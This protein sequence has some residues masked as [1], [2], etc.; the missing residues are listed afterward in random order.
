MPAVHRNGGSRYAARP[1]R[2]GGGDDDDEEKDDGV[3]AAASSLDKGKPRSDSSV[4]PRLNHSSK[5]TARASTS[6]TVGSPDDGPDASSSSPS[7]TGSFALRPPPPVGA[8][9]AEKE[10]PASPAP[11]APS[12]APWKPL[13]ASF[14]ILIP[15]L[16]PPLIPSLTLPNSSADAARRTVSASFDQSIAGGVTS[17]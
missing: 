15:S 12:N 14:A 1:S 17:T 6:T 8:V 9:A 4:D 7:S 10:N 11:P 5:G 13:T 16:I 3:P 2:G